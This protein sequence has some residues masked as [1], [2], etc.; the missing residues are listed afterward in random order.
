MHVVVGHG[1]VGS[2]V[3]RQ[4]VAAGER[5]KVLTRRG[6]P[7][8]GA[9][10]VAVDAAR[11]EDLTAACA[12][13]DVVYSCASPAYHRWER[14]FPALAT[15]ILDAASRTDA[16]LVMA[17][18]LYGYGEV[19]GEL[20]EADPLRARGPKGRTRATI[21]LQAERAHREGRA[22]VTEARAS[23]FYGPGVTT[24]G[25]LAARAIPRLLAG[26][27]VRVLGD[28]EMLR[29]WTY[30]PDFARSMIRLGR[31]P[32]SWGRP[33]H[34]PSPPPA[35]TRRMLELLAASAASPPP[36]VVTTSWHVLWALSAVVPQLRGIEEVRYQFEE[37]F[38][39]DSSAFTSAFGVVAT[40]A[41]A[42][43]DATVEWWLSRQLSR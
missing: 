18:N 43:I 42:S 10:A 21:W 11:A 38:V 37:P 40:D 32:G 29:T 9:E 22:R 4:L 8:D 35:S 7:V 23:D 2:E 14:D 30:V 27:S 3:A 36:T 25:H 6:E 31:E 41:Q 5:V 19:D 24:Q 12:G 28:P 17:G 1:P 34:V 20:H 15:S 39:M 26:R 33:W 13:A 16:V